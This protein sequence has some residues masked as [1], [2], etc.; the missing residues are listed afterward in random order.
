MSL[1]T[2]LLS[3][4]L[5]RSFVETKSLLSPFVLAGLL[6]GLAFT[7]CSKVNDMHDATMAM[8]ATTSK[9]AA[10]TSDLD[11][12]TVGLKGQTKDLAGLMTSIFDSGRQGASVDLRNKQWQEILD[13][14]KP[15]EKAV[16]AELFFQEFEFELWGQVGDDKLADQRFRLM[17]D[18]ATEIMG[19][20]LGVTHWAP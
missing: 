5:V 6:A 8:N 12:N 19:R 10:T 18:A 13:A 1:L 11:A 14:K 7:S 17:Q 9:M 20:L 2:F 16:N 3:T 4:V 15:D